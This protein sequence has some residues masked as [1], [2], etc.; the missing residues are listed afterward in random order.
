MIDHWLNLVSYIVET[1]T[2]EWG[3]KRIVEEVEAPCHAREFSDI[4]DEDS[5][6]SF[7]SNGMMFWHKPG[8]AIVAG[9]IIKFEGK[10]YQVR[11]FVKARRPQGG[12]VQFI[13]SFAE[14]MTEPPA[15]EV[16]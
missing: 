12:G 11:S 8:V 4:V 2:D 1:E 3:Q 10:Y 16:S 15:V 6:R 14:R 13:K 5:R 9:K 7:G